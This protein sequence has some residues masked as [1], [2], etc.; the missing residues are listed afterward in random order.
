MTPLPALRSNKPL[1]TQNTQTPSCLSCK[2]SSVTSLK[3][4]GLMSVILPTGTQSP[5]IRILEDAGKSL[6][7]GDWNTQFL[8]WLI[9]FSRLFVRGCTDA[10]CVS[11]SLCV[12]VCELTQIFCPLGRKLQ[13]AICFRNFSLWFP[14]QTIDKNFNISLIFFLWEDSMYIIC[15]YEYVYVFYIYLCVCVYLWYLIYISKS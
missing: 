9:S 15:M 10:V 6:L 12:F 5:Y 14:T 8:Q 11:F 3:L 4:L 13:N 1:Q 7:C 2:F